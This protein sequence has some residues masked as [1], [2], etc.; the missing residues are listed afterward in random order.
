MKNKGNDAFKNQ[1][2]EEAI[3]FYTKAIELDSS[4]VSFYSNRAACYLNLKKYDE[5]L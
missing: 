2:Y 5:A 4:D 3:D 1:R